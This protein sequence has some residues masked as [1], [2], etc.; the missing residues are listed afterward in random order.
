MTRR[1]PDDRTLINVATGE[2]AP[3]V[4]DRTLGHLAVCSRCSVRYDV[5]RQLKR[6]LHPRVEA[7]IEEHGHALAPGA[8]SGVLAPALQ[9]RR[10]RPFAF[11]AALR[12]APLFALIVLV[13][14][15]GAFLAVSRAARHSHLRSPSAKL[16]LLSPAGAVAAPPA[17]L[18]WSPVLRAEGYVVEVIDDALDSVH[19]DS[20]Y[21]VNELVIPPAVRARLVKGK[22]Y[23]WTVTARDKDSNLLTSG[24]A[25]FVIE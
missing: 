25:S 17:V 15:T 14:G 23:L 11:T 7:F 12:W 2:A 9:S 13:T 5:L 19:T 10:S 1:C 4:K 21:F 22:V 8:P 6:D 18:R 24:S 3:R 16:T 20:A